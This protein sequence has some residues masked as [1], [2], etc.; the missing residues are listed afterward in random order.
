MARAL[1]LLLLLT[2]EPVAANESLLRDHCGAC[3]SHQLIA[4]QRGDEAF[5][6]DIVR[7]MASEQGMAP[8]DADAERAIVEYLAAH[9]GDS[10]WGRRPPIPVALMPR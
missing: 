9:Y 10:D 3:H 2:F 4:A 1:V 6:L 7:L 5:W 8:L